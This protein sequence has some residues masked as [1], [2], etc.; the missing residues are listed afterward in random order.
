MR[1]DR[2]G[3]ITGLA[4]ALLGAAAPAFA[5]TAPAEPALSDELWV[6][7]TSNGTRRM[8][9]AVSIAGGGPYSFIVDTAAERSV[10]SRE[11]AQTLRLGDAGR[12]FLVSMTAT[13]L[14]KWTSCMTA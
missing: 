5:D 3:I 11:L 14:I 9:A 4:A 7:T 12:E 1:G 10:V 8:L 2:R 6:G 13:L